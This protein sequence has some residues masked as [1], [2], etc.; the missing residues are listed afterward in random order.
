M[1]KEIFELNGGIEETNP[2]NTDA[3]ALQETGI[4]GTTKFTTI[5][6]IKINPNILINGGFDIWQRGISF[7][8][9]AFEYMSDRWSGRR[10]ANQSGSTY[11][12]QSA[13]DDGA[14]FAMRV[15]RD[16]GN[17]LTNTLFFG[18][19]IET[20]NA[21]KFRG[22]KLTLS[23]RARKGANYSAGSDALV[24]EIGASNT[25]DRAYD[26]GSTIDTATK[27]LTNSWQTF[28]LT[29][30]AN[31]PST[32]NTINVSFEFIPAGTAGAADYYEVTNVK[33]EVGEV[34]TP[35]VQ[36]QFTEEDALCKWYYERRTNMAQFTSIGAGFILSP[37]TFNGSLFYARKRV[38]PTFTF[39]AANTFTVREAS[40]TFTPS[41]V[42]VS[43]KGVDTATL[44]ADI[45]GASAGNGAMLR[46]GST[47]TFVE[48][49]AEL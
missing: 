48:I 1:A 19:A 45:V 14:N 9:G 43:A 7:V 17:A 40:G 38:V 27:T 16:N 12:Q 18:Q 21:I 10:S 29:T 41:A 36:R 49:I 31:I 35:Y 2:D 8:P 6:R 25:V 24:V 37:T 47:A 20:T 3:I 34:V 30:S 42:S 13:S 39:S 33:L 46:A 5:G 32:T 11:S 28:S 23:F 26:G 15:Q 22:K 4:G 44:A